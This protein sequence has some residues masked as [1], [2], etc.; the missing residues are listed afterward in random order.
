MNRQTSIKVGNIAAIGGS[1]DDADDSEDDTQESNE[2][3]P[4][5][6][7]YQR[8]QDYQHNNRSYQNN[9]NSS[10]PEQF[11]SV[12]EVR[13]EYDPETTHPPPSN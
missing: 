7:G 2:N 10:K 11:D 6:K 3:S 12:V 8:L 1:D 9:Q 13:L 4:H 5:E